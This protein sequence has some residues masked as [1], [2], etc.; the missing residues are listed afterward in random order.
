MDENYTIDVE[1]INYM[2]QQGTLDN[3]INNIPLDYLRY[4][5]ATVQPVYSLKDFTREDMGRLVVEY[6]FDWMALLRFH[7]IVS[8]PALYKELT[9]KTSRILSNI[10]ALNM[11]L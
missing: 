7:N 11:L 1:I 2:D 9:E 5:W 3:I 8:D 4:M 6:I 10:V